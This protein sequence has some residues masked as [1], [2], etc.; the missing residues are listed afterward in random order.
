MLKCF[1]CGETGCDECN[2]TGRITITGCPLR[3]IDDDIW[4]VIELCRLYDKG[5]PPIAGG[6]LDQMRAFIVAFGIYE[7]TMSQFKLTE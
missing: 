6:S 3:F 7:Q 1:M 2:Q 4:N 5:L